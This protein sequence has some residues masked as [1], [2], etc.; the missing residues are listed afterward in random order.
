M[1]SAAKKTFGHEKNLEVK[2][3]PDLG[4]VEL[5]EIKTVVEHLED[6]ENQVT[7]EVARSK[8]DPE[9][10]TG[11]Q[12]LAKLPSEKFGRVAAQGRSGGS[13]RRPW[14]DGGHHNRSEGAAMRKSRTGSPVREAL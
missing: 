13:F 4:E 14:Q 3:N 8:M 10:E 6:P 12:L 11:D 9:A 2:F 1:L 5:F 7:L